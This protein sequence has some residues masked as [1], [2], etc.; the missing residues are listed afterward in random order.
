MWENCQF[1][2][3]YCIKLFEK[4]NKKKQIAI[5][6]M[7]KYNIFTENAKNELVKCEADNNTIFNNFINEYNLYIKYNNKAKFKPWIRKF[8]PISLAG[9][10]IIILLQFIK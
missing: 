10:I 5:E 9:N 1:Q 2:Q 8:L 6:V 4:Y 7:Q 3:Q